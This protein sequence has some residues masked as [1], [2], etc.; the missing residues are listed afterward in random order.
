M[1]MLDHRLKTLNEHIRHADNYSK[2]SGL[3]RQRQQLPCRKQAAV[4]ERHRAELM[5]YEATEAYLRGVLNERTTIPV[6]EWKNEAAQLTAERKS[7]Y[8][9]H[10]QIKEETR[11][12]EAIRYCVEHVMRGEP[13]ICTRQERE[14]EL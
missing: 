13:K 8:A 11:S 2:C 6:K 4:Y 5:L 3:H 14:V 9:E 10:A 1:K 12:V 7:L